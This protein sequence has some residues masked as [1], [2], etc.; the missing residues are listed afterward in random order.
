MTQRRP[1]E[2]DED[3]DVEVDEQ[4]APLSATFRGGKQEPFHTWY[5]Y[6]EGYSLEF[7]D[8]E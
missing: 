8:I 5:P 4:F 2:C 7:V 6:L 1:G 3:V